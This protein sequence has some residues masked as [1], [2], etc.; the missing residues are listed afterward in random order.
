MVRI[1]DPLNTQADEP[2]LWQNMFSAAT[3]ARFVKR[4]QFIWTKAHDD[5]PLG[6]VKLFN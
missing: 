3:G 6:L 2:G 1:F 5:H 4:T